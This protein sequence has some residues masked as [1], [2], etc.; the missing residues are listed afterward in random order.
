ML[1]FIFILIHCLIVLHL[2]ILFDRI[3]QKNND[4]IV[5]SFN[6]LPDGRKNKMKVNYAYHNGPIKTTEGS[7]DISVVVGVLSSTPNAEARNLIRSTWGQGAQF[8]FIIFV[9]SL[10]K[11][12]RG[13]TIELEKNKDLIL[14]EGTEAY[15]KIAIKVAAFF[16]AI[17]QM[18]HQFT[19]VIK[20]DDDSYI[21]MTRLIQFLTS[22]NKS[23][24]YGGLCRN[25]STVIRDPKNKFYVPYSVLPKQQIIFPSYAEGAGYILSFEAAV[26]TAAHS[27]KHPMISSEDAN[28]GFFLSTYC[29]TTCSN[30]DFVSI[31]F[32][33]Y[34]SSSIIQHWLPQN[35]I[36][37]YHSYQS[38]SVAHSGIYHNKEVGF[39]S[40]VNE[41]SSYGVSNCTVHAIIIDED[42]GFHGRMS[43]RATW[44]KNDSIL[45]CIFVLPQ[46]AYSKYLQESNKHKDIHF[47]PDMARNQIYLAMAKVFAEAFVTTDLIL[48]VKHL[49][50]ISSLQITRLASANKFDVLL[51]DGDIFAVQLTFL[52][53]INS[54]FASRT[55]MN[56]AMESMISTCSNSPGNVPIG[57]SLQVTPKYGKPLELFFIQHHEAKE[58]EAPLL[59]DCGYCSFPA[60]KVGPYVIDR[61][62]R[63]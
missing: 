28:T 35:L 19:H 24:Q 13:V 49:S 8:F 11:L 14:V 16:Q 58:K 34:D 30:F 15:G 61:K 40:K 26:C 59:K 5:Q 55:I 50:Y 33:P 6:V 51:K 17:A 38:S 23:V 44:C 25:Q 21:H 46:T 22:H 12:S 31:Y 60:K 32:D 56:P 41:I 45:R 3:S 63:F 53:C 27:D 39:R 4:F 42:I 62:K 29:N 10:H 20:T 36:L 18:E 54:H 2:A 9:P 37:P 52:S 48:F 57:E 7:Q 47:V 1:K 43:M